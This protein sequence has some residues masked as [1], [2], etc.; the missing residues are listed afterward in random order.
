MKY[1]LKPNICVWLTIC[2][3]H[4]IVSDIKDY[5]SSFLEGSEVVII[6][7][8]FITSD[9]RR[10][11][12]T[13]DISSLPVT[14]FPRASTWMYV[15]ASTSGLFLL[16]RFLQGC[17]MLNVWGGHHVH[18]EKNLECSMRF[19]P[20]CLRKTWNNRKWLHLH[21]ICYSLFTTHND[22]RERFV[23]LLFQ[24]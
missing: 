24:C 5:I 20:V 3:G 12:R 23:P 4:C 17:S 19:L 13:R 11:S 22:R 15:T 1:I 7:I 6:R 16:A 2:G 9:W 8:S 18:S 10:N 21:V 14:T